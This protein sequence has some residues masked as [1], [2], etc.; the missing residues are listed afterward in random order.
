M[1]FR[2]QPSYFSSLL[3]HQ[4]SAGTWFTF[5]GSWSQWSIIYRSIIYVSIFLIK[6]YI[7][8]WLCQVLVAAPVLWFLI[9]DR[10]EDSCIGSAESGPPG[11]SQVICYVL[12]SLI[13]MSVAS[14]PRG[15]FYWL[16]SPPVKEPNVLEGA[17]EW[18]L[19]QGYRRMPSS[20]WKVG[21]CWLLL[22]T[23]ISS[24]GRCWP[25]ISG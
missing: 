5:L 6:K 16:E 4:S 21:S 10:T 12:M 3:V 14:I 11:K 22:L 19:G 17:V 2:L 24:V 20:H 15:R 25:A 23:F 9:R 7:F 8:I 18:Y 1:C 13:K